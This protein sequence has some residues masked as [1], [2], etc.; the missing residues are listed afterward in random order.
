M[1]GGCLSLF[2]YVFGGEIMGMGMG[3]GKW[4]DVWIYNTSRNRILLGVL[5]RVRELYHRGDEWME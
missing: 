5:Y 1:L 3:M 2:L 4:M